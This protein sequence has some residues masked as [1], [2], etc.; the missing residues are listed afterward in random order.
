MFLGGFQIP[1]MDFF[2]TTF[3]ENFTEK[4]G[5]FHSGWHLYTCQFLRGS[6]LIF[7]RTWSQGNQSISSAQC[8]PDYPSGLAMARPTGNS[9]RY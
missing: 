9:T 4:K 1:G 5:T 6:F 2:R 7:F 8:T 3:Q